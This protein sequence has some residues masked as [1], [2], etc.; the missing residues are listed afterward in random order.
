MQCVASLDGKKWHRYDRQ[1]YARPAP[2]EHMVYMGRGAVVR[3]DEI[4]QYGIAYQTHH[5]EVDLRAKHGDG[6]I[7]RF[8]QRL[9]GFVSADSGTRGRLITR[10]LECN[11]ATLR[12]NVDS[13]GIGSARV[14]LLDEFGEPIDGYTIESCNPVKL[15]STN[16]IVSW[17]GRS[18]IDLR[19]K[20]VRIVI[21]SNRT[22]L[23]ALW[24]E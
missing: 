9:D 2:G 14:A 11:G 13:D 15:N 1:S 24:F 23:Y 7:Y 3:R 20:R 17:R 5:G 8:V 22:K 6:T 21:E 10:P 19:G 18:D 12:L 4:W 16:A